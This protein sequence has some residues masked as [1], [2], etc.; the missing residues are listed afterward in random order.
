MI[1]CELY[2]HVLKLVIGSLDECEK[3]QPEY[4]KEL[5]EDKKVPVRFHGIIE[6]QRLTW[7]TP[8]ARIAI[9]KELRDRDLATRLRSN[10]D[11]IPSCLTLKNLYGPGSHLKVKVKI[12]GTQA[13]SAVYLLSKHGAV[14]VAAKAD[15]RPRYLS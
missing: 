15:N 1:S 5:Y 3:F 2:P 4:N 13:N 6:I 12:Q 8:E 7:L 14:W 10:S 9:E 11:A